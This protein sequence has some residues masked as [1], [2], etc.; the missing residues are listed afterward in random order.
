LIISRFVVFEEEKV[1]FLLDMYAPGVL[2]SSDS[3]DSKQKLKGADHTLFDGLFA[4]HQVG[5]CFCQGSLSKGA[6]GMDLVLLVFL[7]AKRVPVHS[8]YLFVEFMQFS[9]GREG[10]HFHRVDFRDVLRKVP[11]VDCLDIG[12]V[13]LHS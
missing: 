11:F 1:S 12:P 6:D 2:S 9:L 8:F 3:H 5:G 10:L 4:V 13:V 7:E